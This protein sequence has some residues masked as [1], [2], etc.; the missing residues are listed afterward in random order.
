MRPIAITDITMRQSSRS[1]DFSLSFQEK[2]ELCKLLDRLGVNAIETTPITTS[3]A[4]SLL[5][6]SIAS[7]VRESTL[8]VPVGLD[9]DLIP[10]AEKAL[11]E[12]RHPRLV[13]EAPVSSVQMEYLA[14]KKPAAMIDTIRHMI[15]ACR[16]VCTDV[17]FVAEDAT[18][19]EASFIRDA[20]GAA[21]EAGASIITVSDTAGI[22]LP[23]EFAAFLS[24]LQADVPG[25]ESVTLGVSCSNTLYMADACAISAIS[26]GAD[27][28]KA[29]GY[30]LGS[31]SL[32]HIV[33]LIASRGDQINA[34]TSVHTTQLTRATAQI[35][36][37]CRT[38]EK[39]RDRQSESEED[40][41]YLTA[42]DDMTAVM[43]AVA[44][45]GYELSEE[46]TVRVYEAFSR[47][48]TKKEKVSTR[49][50]DAIVA[51]AA[52]QVPATYTVER[53]IINTGNV[54]HPSA[55]I[56]LSKNGEILE[57]ISLGDGPIDAAFH[58]IEEIIGH[59][60][61]LDDFQIQA[62]TEGREAMGEAIVKLRSGGKLYSGQG[63]S[64]DIVGSSIRAYIN[65]L[66]K[67]VYEEGQ[68]A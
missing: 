45:L 17:E 67:V 40:G 13:V 51:S 5:I 10:I 18:R 44:T 32:K 65:A 27:E 55:S 3:R 8:A 6:K 7:I 64:T 62:V 20:I 58:T 38:G 56:Q 36:R 43:A 21:I 15:E 63:I 39:T 41:L 19:A 12:A 16:K 49:E 1:E 47:I 35:T 37:L 52:M 53:Y 59:H 30:N 34:S 14:S 42:H 29:A 50:L 24:D 31:I 4:T 23:D 26:A 33:S 28:V 57:G 22:M 61:D 25:L 46:D 9:P 68:N 2:I 11:Q 48:A 60:Y 66:N 54:I